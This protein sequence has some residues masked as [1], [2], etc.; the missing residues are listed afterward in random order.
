MF[1]NQKQ[2]LTSM[3]FRMLST[4]KKYVF[5]SFVFIT[6]LKITYSS[7]PKCTKRQNIIGTCSKK[8][9]LF[10]KLHL[11]V[12]EIDDVGKL[13][14]YNLS[15]NTPTVEHSLPLHVHS[16]GFCAVCIKLLSASLISTND[17]QH[18]H[19]RFEKFGQSKSNQKPFCKHQ[20]WGNTI[21]Q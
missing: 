14:H 1:L 4:R 8:E 15:R 9:E 19:Y 20:L 18:Y 10:M 5:H 3:Q 7:L 21:A 2:I 17:V 12:H 6:I 16:A 13:G 11:S